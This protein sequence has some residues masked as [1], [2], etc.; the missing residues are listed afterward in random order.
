MAW[1]MDDTFVGRKRHPFL[2]AG[3]VGSSDHGMVSRQSAGF[4]LL[5]LSEQEFSCNTPTARL[6]TAARPVSMH[7]FTVKSPGSGVLLPGFESK[8]C[9]L[10]TVS[11]GKFTT[12]SCH[13]FLM[14]DTGII[15]HLYLIVLP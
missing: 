5:L 15:F 4:Q 6:Y 8:L 9:S 3:G 11:L 2:Q 10:L 13:S 12:S 14:S 7:F 1:L